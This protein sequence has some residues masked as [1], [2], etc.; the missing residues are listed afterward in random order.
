MDP[1]CVSINLGPLMQGKHKCQL[2]NATDKCLASEK[3]FTYLAIE[4]IVLAFRNCAEIFKSGDKRDGVHV[5]K[6]ENQSAF[7]VFCDQTTAGGGWTLFQRRIDGSVDFN[8]K[9]TDYKQGFGNITAEFWLGLERIHHLTLDNNSM[10]RVDLEDFD[11]NTA[12]AE[13]SLFGVRSELNKYHLILRSY[14]GTAGDSFSYH[15]GWPFSTPDQD[16]DFKS[17]G[18]CAIEYEGES[19][20]ARVNN[21]VCDTASSFKRCQGGVD[22]RNLAFIN[23]VSS[24]TRLFQVPKSLFLNTC[25]LKKI[26]NRVR[27]SV[28]LAA[29]FR[30]WDID[31]GVISETHLCRQKPDSIVAL[32]GYTIYRRDRDWAG[33][34]KRKKG[35]VAVYVR[36]NLKVLNVNR[37]RS[38]EMLSVELLLPSGHHMLMTGLYHPPSFHYDEGDLIDTIIDRC[39]TFLDMHPNGVVLCGGDLNRLDLDCL[40]TSSGLVPMDGCVQFPKPRTW[41]N[42]VWDRR[43][44]TVMTISLINR[45]TT[46]STFRAPGSLFDGMG[47]LPGGL[48]AFPVE[49]GGKSAAG[50]DNASSWERRAPDIIITTRRAVTSPMTG[51]TTSHAFPVESTISGLVTHDFANRAER[52]YAAVPDTNRIS[53]NCNLRQYGFLKRH[54][55]DRRAGEEVRSPHKRL[56]LTEDNFPEMLE[57]VT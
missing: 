27:A 51:L 20:T 54:L 46:G 45:S 17:T 7:D 4:F 15:N 21:T 16:N 3:D 50:G 2:N 22:W 12:Y 41:R 53:V 30:S 9:W 55:K 44:E 1:D 52:F 26:K 5:I 34:D 57:V 23:I 37:Q 11:G 35:G 56:A 39:D 33:T 42:S 8:L 13:Y 32:E 31:V 38:F 28:A 25:S 40:S 6:P 10:L 36:E 24:S 29:D 19:P 47:A 18:N 14:T 48:A 49:I 43:R